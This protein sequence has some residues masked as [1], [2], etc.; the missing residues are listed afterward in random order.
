MPTA[1]QAFKSQL[2]VG[3]RDAVSPASTK[4]AAGRLGS[5]GPQVK[6]LVLGGVQAR[7]PDPA[8]HR[9]LLQ[10]VL[11]GIR[12]KKSS[13]FGSVP[14]W[15]APFGECLAADLPRRPNRVTRSGC[16]SF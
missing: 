3:L 5:S 8:V 12:V 9:H 1:A 2:F 15:R 14:P 10:I 13:L 4:G 11:H 6:Q 16:G 7:A